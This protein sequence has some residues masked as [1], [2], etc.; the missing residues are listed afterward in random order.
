MVWQSLTRTRHRHGLATQASELLAVP[1][2]YAATACD[3]APDSDAWM[4]VE[5]TK[6]EARM[7]E[8]ERGTR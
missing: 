3:D 5:A 6:I 7:S 1:G 2:P 4:E 8:Q